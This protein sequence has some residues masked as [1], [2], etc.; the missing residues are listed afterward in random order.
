M[1]DAMSEDRRI[2]EGDHLG[3]HGNEQNSIRNMRGSA[4]ELVRV[5][6]QMD[7]EYN[8]GDNQLNNDSYL[9]AL[10]RNVQ[11]HNDE[12]IAYR[13]QGILCRVQ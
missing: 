9:N 8:S 2:E 5:L 10:L 12:R 3:E 6:N 1:S 4:E 13:T 7:S 11:I